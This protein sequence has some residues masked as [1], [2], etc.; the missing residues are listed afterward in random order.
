MIIANHAHLMPEPGADA[1]WPAGGTDML[2]EHIDYCGI[3]KAVV[4]PP[5]ACQMDN[6]ITKANR[7][8][9]QEVK[10]HPDRLIAAGVINPVAENAVELLSIFQAEGIKHAK[11]HP[12]VDKHDISSPLADACYEKAEALEIALDY[13]TGVHGT[14]LSMSNP[15]KFDDIA[16]KYP[17]LKMIFEHIGGRTY[18]EQFLAIMTNH[19]NRSKEPCIFGGI[20]SVLSIENNRFWYLGPEKIMDII[21]FAGAD[22]LVFGLDFPWNSKE[23][24]KRD[25]EI[26]E[27]LDISVK[28]KEKIL[29]GN[30]SR[31]IEC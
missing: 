10:K 12:S 4:F 24:N 15:E 5:F 18:F 22:S 30:L 3:N 21:E 29:G 27:Q 11:V 2:L 1:W 16:W 13:H 26:I 23:I 25:I 9:W 17:G 19:A 20:T 28:N 7:W 14:Q 31:I 8:A 6:D